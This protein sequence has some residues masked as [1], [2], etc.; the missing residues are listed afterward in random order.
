LEGSESHGRG[1]WRISP[2]VRDEEKGS[3][4][5]EES[6][7]TRLP[8]DQ[9]PD[10]R[11]QEELTA[12]LKSYSDGD[13]SRV[14]SIVPV[15]IEDVWDITVEGDASYLAHGFVNHNSSSPV[16]GQNIPRASSMHGL[17]GVRY[18][19]CAALPWAETDDM[20]LFGADFSQIELRVAAHLACDPVM[21]AVYQNKTCKDEP[22]GIPCD[23]YIQGH[24]CIGEG[25][26]WSGLVL[27]GS[28][29]PKCDGAALE[30][31]ARCRHMDLHQ[32]TA[33]DCGVPRSL[34]KALNFG[35]L[36]R[37][38]PNRFCD[39][40]AL[41]DDRGVKRIP[42]AKEIQENW[43][44]VYAGIPEYHHHVEAELKKNGWVSFT[45]S[46]RRR[47]LKELAQ[48]PDKRYRAV[49]Q[50]IQYA[51]SGSAQDIM[52]IS[53]IKIWRAIKK[54]IRESKKAIADQWRRVKFMIQVHDE[55]ILT[56]PKCLTDE[57]KSL[58]KK[59]MEGVVNPRVFKVP[60]VVEAKH[61]RTWRDIH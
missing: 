34:A 27:P 44:N 35:N 58:M 59:E 24:S 3:G 32:R 57:I 61:G 51:I 40:A 29:C 43:M 37:Q 30:W 60:L 26:G 31:Q 21:I 1:R 12:R 20:L 25:C 10:L 48:D 23:R 42:Y 2:E 49:T 56:G 41:F 53:M 55:I 47:R 15:G 11:Y 46:G 18:A 5:G 36:Y 16:N 28:K 45:I 13:W 54:L 4:K 52:K 17:P 9:V 7:G 33:E 6:Q 39:T 19:F 8:S 38:G 14:A 50:G 22:G